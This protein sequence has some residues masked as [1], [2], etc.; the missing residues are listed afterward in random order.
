MIRIWTGAFT[1]G[2]WSETFD[3]SLDSDRTV[4]FVF[5][6]SRW[7]DDDGPLAQLRHAFPRSHFMGC[8]TAGE[9]WGTKVLDESI[10]AAA[11]RFDSSNLRIASLALDSQP[12]ACALGTR[13]ATELDAPDLAGVF[14]LSDGLG[15][16]GSALTRGIRYALGNRVPV[17]GGLA[18]DGPRFS[19][20]WV[21]DRGRPKT[22]VVAALGFYGDRLRMRHGS[23]GGWDIFGHERVVTKASGNVLLELDGRPALDLYRRYLGDR[24]AG[25]PATALLFPLAIRPSDDTWSPSTEMVARPTTL[26]RT[27]LGVDEGNRSMTFA[28]DVPTGWRAQLMRANF[29]RLIQGAGDAAGRVMHARGNPAICIAV[30]CVGRRLVLGTRSEEELEMVM[31][32]VPPGT[33]QLGF[34]SY[35]EISPLARTGCDLHNQTMTLT[36]LEET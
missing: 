4:I 35:G 34:Y 18:A 7:A 31:D 27:I 28:G 11:M 10:V 20:T 8:S 14:V 3:R 2:R 17:T 30:S 26:V 1:D 19:R 23:G 13:L 24:A 12:D 29:D 6:A 25:L 22:G 21:L 16:N 15:I 33:R 36:T 32:A 5:G 9:I